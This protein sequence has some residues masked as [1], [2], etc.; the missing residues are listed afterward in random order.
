MPH[1]LARGWVIILVVLLFDSPPLLH[2]VRAQDVDS[3]CWE[4]CLAQPGA[5]QNEYYELYDLITSIRRARTAAAANGTVFLLDDNVAGSSTTAATASATYQ[6]QKQMAQLLSMA[7]PTTTAVNPFF[8]AQYDNTESWY[9]YDWQCLGRC[10]AYDFIDVSLS[11]YS[12]ITADRSLLE[13]ACLAAS[14][15]FDMDGDNAAADYSCLQ[16]TSNQLV[17]AIVNGPFQTYQSTAAANGGSGSSSAG[18]CDEEEQSELTP[19]ELGIMNKNGLLDDIMN[20]LDDTTDLILNP[21]IEFQSYCSFYFGERRFIVGTH[22]A[23]QDDMDTWAGSE[24]Q[25]KFIEN[26]VDMM[27]AM[28]QLTACVYSECCP[29]SAVGGDGDP[30]QCIRVDNSGISSYSPIG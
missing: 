16:Y 1:R 9:C 13:E 30:T 8:A 7:S 23:V 21:E 4:G 26:S 11:D 24:H 2:V 5:Y 27:E 20:E 19:E 22:E 6:F 18:L 15:A 14:H 29:T 10:A 28:A 25:T 3:D 12:S 17:V